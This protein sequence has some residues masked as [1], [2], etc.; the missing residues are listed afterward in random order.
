MGD[1]FGLRPVAQRSD[2][3]SARPQTPGPS[4]SA[5][6]NMAL[7]VVGM[8][9]EFGVGVVHVG[10]GVVGLGVGDPAETVAFGVLGLGR[11]G[12]SSTAEAV[13]LDVVGGDLRVDWVGHRRL[14]S[15]VPAR[16]PTTRLP[17]SGCPPLSAERHRTCQLGDS[18]VPSTRGRDG[19]G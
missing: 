12:V 11:F 13:A 1:T 2:P 8:F 7:D 15:L 18:S 9:I 6:P 14:L 5:G 4:C 3:A 19:S 16:L 17:D 10:L